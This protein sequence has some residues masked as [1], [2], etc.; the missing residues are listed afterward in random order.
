MP[1]PAPS[2]SRWLRHFEGI[3]KREAQRRLE[4]LSAKGTKSSRNS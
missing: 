1:A 3:G 2:S 4:Q